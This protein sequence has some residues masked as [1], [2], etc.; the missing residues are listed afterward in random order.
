MGGPER[1]NTTPPTVAYHG[2]EVRGARVAETAAESRLRGVIL[3]GCDDS[4]TVLSTAVMHAPTTHKPAYQYARS[5]TQSQTVMCAAPE[6]LRRKD[7]YKV[8]CEPI[9]RVPWMVEADLLCV[10]A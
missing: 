10:R 2:Y 8:K 1:P 4:H 5:T 9:N 3:T 6:H 7:S